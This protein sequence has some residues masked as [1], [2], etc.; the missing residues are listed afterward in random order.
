MRQI[1][2][3][4]ITVYTMKKGRSLENGNM[5]QIYAAKTNHITNPVGFL[6]NPVVFSWK[7]RECRGKNQRCARI[8]V[9]KDETFADVLWDTGEAKLDSLAVKA[10]MNLEPCTRYYWKVIVTTDA[11]EVL[12]SDVQFFE[13]AKRDEPWVGKWITC[14]SRMERH[15]IFSKRIIPRGKV[16]K[17]RLYLCGLG[18]YEAYFTDGE[19]TETDILKSAKIGEE[20]LTPYCN[21]YTQWLQYQ[22]YDVT[23]QMQ[24]E[25]VLS[26]LLGNGWYKG[27]FGLNQTEQK[28]FYGDE[29]KLL[30]EVHLEYEDGTQEIIGTDDT[31]EV[32]R[33]NLFF[34]NIYD[35]EKRDD[36]LEPVEP[37]SAQLAE[38]PQGRLTERLSLP[39]TVHEQFT[40]KE[41]I[42]TPK[43]EWVFDLGQEI[44]G[45][46]KL[47][48]HEPK[49]KE[50]R[51]Q[52]GEILQDGCFYNENLRTALSEYVYISDGEEKDIVPHFTFYGYRYV[53]ISGV[54]NVSCEDFTG[55]ALY[56]DYE[57]TGSIQTGNELVN[58]LISN[59]EWGMKDNFL[60][61]PTD[62]PQR[63]E[64][65]GWT[66]DTQVFSGTA[67][68]LADTYAFYRKYLY[69]LYKEQLIAGGMV[70][71]V[72]PT[73]GPSKCSC[74]WGDAACI[75]PWNVYL[76][77]GDAA[78][79]EQQFDSMKAWVDYIRKVD[80]EHHGWRHSFHYGDWL[81]LDRV[82]AAAGNV[83]G[84]TDEG[85]IADIYYAASAELTAKAAAVLGRKE[86]EK[87]YREIAE[88]Q[89]RVV[90]EEYFTPTGRCAEKTQTGLLLALKYHL[91]EDE[92]LTR[93][94]L[95]KLFRES[96]NKL[97]TGFVG[98]SLLCN[99][100]TDNGMTDT[101]YRLLLN[102]EY[103][104]WLHEVKLGATTVWE[105]WNSLDEDGKISSTGMNSL[106][107]YSYGAILEWMFRHV[108]GI[109]L[110]EESPGGRRVA[111][112]PNVHY[113]LRQVKTVYDS[114]SGRYE[115]GWEITDDNRIKISITIP[116]GGEGEV[117]LPHAPEI[118]FEDK[119]NPLFAT[120]VNGICYITAGNYEVVYEATEKLK[121]IY[122]VESKLEDLLNHPQI[123]AFLSTMTEVD[124]IPD[125]VYGLSFR[126]VA[127]M[128][129]GPMD[130]G[131]A[132]ML[133]TAL[134]QY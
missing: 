76:F 18:L 25:G 95:K 35:G 34:S 9:A 3:T 107:H 94:M 23:A 22:T 126:Q 120:V 58:Q 60:D 48:V 83:Y 50:I 84:A 121:K 128:F 67:C 100:L 68:Y 98:T 106:N 20:Y 78:I 97:N 75:V 123:R 127:E 85:Y 45:I 131:Q 33:S 86:E 29:W 108:G 113:D 32:T 5:N 53:K 82:G 40:P 77:S 6:L 31:W 44:T 1:H 42:H 21:N 92:E 111:I 57:G 116:F 99:V 134:S 102:E 24:R 43:D 110:L 88:K 112:C 125:A 122:S 124:M 133:N 8:L 2:Y 4:R 71:E 26:V 118:L 59:V 15:P 10:E 109:H 27:R 19:K 89:W 81:A 30:V 114:A 13:T 96:R 93:E 130:E 14:D 129:S 104:G 41:L 16:K 54:T 66:G 52:T 74:A 103:P 119:T 39:V 46:F 132:E 49:G 63:D 17:A 12:E 65:M 87:Q 11:D 117:R 56:S 70:P 79:L 62:C 38:A 73:F 37:V 91:S 61:V 80:G 69:D 64:R 28:G 36:T 47:H 72:V 105:R 55:M 115:C 51:I 101:A 90:K 7:V